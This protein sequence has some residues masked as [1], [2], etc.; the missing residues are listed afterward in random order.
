MFF[1]ILL[2]A[3]SAG[4]RAFSFLRRL[5]SMSVK[6]II[7]AHTKT[8]K[9]AVNVRTGSRG[10]SLSGPLEIRRRRSLAPFVANFISGEKYGEEG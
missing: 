10:G 9:T 4:V 7:S 5:N 2:D 6:A 1:A 8:V 3:V